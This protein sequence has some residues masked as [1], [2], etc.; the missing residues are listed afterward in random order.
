MKEIFLVIFISF[1]SYFIG[2]LVISKREKDYETRK[3]ERATTAGDN[4]VRAYKL[5][6]QK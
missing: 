4:A 3:F 2:L 5:R 1:L 6:K